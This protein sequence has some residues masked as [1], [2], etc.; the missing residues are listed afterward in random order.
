MKNWCNSG[1][2]A[3]RGSAFRLVRIM[4]YNVRFFEDEGVFKRMRAMGQLIQKHSP[5]VIL[6]QE[7]TKMIYRMFQSSEWWKLY[8]CFLPQDRETDTPFCF[9]LSKLPL[10]A[11][12]KICIDRSA[13]RE[14][15]AAKLK[16]G[17]NGSLVVVSN[18]GKNPNISEKNCDKRQAQA[19]EVL[20]HLIHYPNVVFGG[21]M[22][23]DVDSDGK[24]PLQGSW[25]DP[26]AQARRTES[27]LLRGY[28]PNQKRSD[29]FVCKLSDFKVNGIEMIG[30]E[31]IPETSNSHKKKENF[32]LLLTLSNM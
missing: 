22:N 32:G 13:G 28:Q 21:E 6:F 19:I 3:Y 5:D 2:Y 1:D 29:K 30:M 23:W 14:V 10:E 20:S 24:F 17:S 12:I 15:R 25:F 26:L 18:H 9:Q 27:G 31:D 8:E 7:V 11:I 16:V 4:S